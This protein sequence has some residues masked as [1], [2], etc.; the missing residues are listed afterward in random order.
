M[1]KILNM[2]SDLLFPPN[3]KCICCGD[4]INNNEI[5]GICTN[6]L[7]DFVYIINPCPTCG[8]LMPNENTYCINCKKREHTFFNRHRSVFIYEKTAKRLILNAKFSGKKYLTENMAH[9]LCDAYI[10][11]R[12]NCDIITYVPSGIKRTKERGYNVAKLLAEAL[13]KEVNVEVVNTMDRVIESHQINKDYKTRQE[14][15][16]NAFKV[17]DNI[18]IEDKRVLIVDDVY[19]TGATIN[20]CARILKLAG[21]KVVF[22]LTFAHTP[23]KINNEKK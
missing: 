15:I 4:E 5:N 1:K 18:N 23:K 19:T 17:L 3:I 7:R 22:G 21:A 6:C 9:F 8:D 20:E 11:N 14:N 2:L 13:G 10:T 12:F 16:K